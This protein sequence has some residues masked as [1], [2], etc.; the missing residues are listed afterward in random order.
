MPQLLS[1]KFGDEYDYTDITES[2][3]KKFK[4]GAVDVYVDSKL[5][6]FVDKATNVKKVK[7]E[8]DEKQEINDTVAEMCG[9]NDQTCMEVKR[10]ELTKAKLAEKEAA[11]TSSTAQVIKGRRLTVK[12]RD[13]S[14]QEK[15]MVVPEGQQF[16]LGN[17]GKGKPDGPKEPQEL[18]PPAW[19][20]I[21]ESWWGIL[22]SAVL[23]FLYVSSIIIT[24]MT[25]VKYGSKMVAG[26]MVAI[27]VFIPYSGFALSFFGPFIAE[28]FRVD[29]LARLK[30]TVPEELEALTKA[31][32][33]MLPKTAE[34]IIPKAPDLSKAAKDVALED[35]SKLAAD[36]KGGRF[37]SRR[38]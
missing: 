33:S 37:L 14:G 17:L 36:M 12:Y 30:A 7:L 34:G 18:I 23:A 20:Q 35:P 4:E 5:I 21:F 24:W 9:P 2:L 38:K 29:K 8:D 3:G 28:Y 26:G 31:D 15:T 27:S 22:G 10:E 13:D 1:A 16:Q 6:P 19:K 11:K 25:F 32:P